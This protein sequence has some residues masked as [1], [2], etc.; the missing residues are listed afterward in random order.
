MDEAVAIYR[1]LAKYPAV[2]LGMISSEEAPGHVQVYSEWTQRDLDRGETVK[3]ARGHIIHL[4]IVIPTPPYELTNELVLHT[5][6]FKI[7]A[8]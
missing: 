4:D 2:K 8:S 6:R 5:S 1:E 3:F 7:E